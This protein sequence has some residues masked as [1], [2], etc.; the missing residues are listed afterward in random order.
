MAATDAA[1]SSPVAQWITFGTKITALA[2][3]AYFAKQCFD[4][5]RTS[6]EQKS[7]SVESYWGGLGGNLGGW[8]VSKSLVWFVVTLTVVG[9]FGALVLH[10]GDD[11]PISSGKDQSTQSSVDKQK[12]SSAGSIL[13][14]TL[15][16]KSGAVASQPSATPAKADS[17]GQKN[18][19]A[20]A[21][22]K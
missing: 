2:I 19:K 20:E 15:E 8:S 6:L 18:N 7:L 5:L 22:H 17:E 10:I 13:N 16:P 21:N 14:P 9:L 12:T 11:I 4:Q 3:L 1:T